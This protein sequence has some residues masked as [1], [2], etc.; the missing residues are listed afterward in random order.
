M[1]RPTPVSHYVVVAE[2][3]V[4]VSE[5]ALPGF[6]ELE[7]LGFEACSALVFIDLVRAACSSHRRMVTL[8]I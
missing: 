7:A 5:I 3:F 4:E 8:A 2:D 1:S 6:A